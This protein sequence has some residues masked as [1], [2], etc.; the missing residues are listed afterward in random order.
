MP[1]EIIPVRVVREGN[2]FP[3]GYGGNTAAGE[4]D[5]EGSP[6]DARLF[7]AGSGGFDREREDVGETTIEK[8]RVL[9]LLDP[10]A[11][12][13]I[14]EGDTFIIPACIATGGVETRATIKR[15]RHYA[16][17][18]QCDLETGDAQTQRVKDHQL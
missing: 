15:I 9:T 5:I 18:V 4:Q 16:R 2:N 14:Q 1:R 11:A 10:V 8:R 3:D 13:A 17:T 7:R 12:R 6:F